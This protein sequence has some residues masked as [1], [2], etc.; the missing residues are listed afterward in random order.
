MGRVDSD[1]EGPASKHQRLFESLP[2]DVLV[3][4]QEANRE[5]AVDRR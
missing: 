1:L 5:D 2:L 4:A 3:L